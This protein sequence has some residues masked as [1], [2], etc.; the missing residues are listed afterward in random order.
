MHGLP[1][2]VDEL[3]NH[4]E[5]TI[6]RAAACSGRRIWQIA[7]FLWCR[8]ILKSFRPPQTLTR[9]QV[10][11]Y[12]GITT[13]IWVATI[14]FRPEVLP[15][16]L[17]GVHSDRASRYQFADAQ[18]LYESR[19]IAFE[20]V[21]M[22]TGFAPPVV[23]GLEDYL[24]EETKKLVADIDDGHVFD[25]PPHLPQ[26]PTQLAA[27]YSGTV[28]KVIR[29]RLKYGVP[30]ED[31]YNEMWVKILH[32][33][34]VLKFV[35]SAPKRLPA[36]LA[37]EDVLDFFGIDLPEWQA[38][39]KS[40]EKAPNPVKGQATSLDAV[41]R[42]DDIK[43]L[44]D[45]GYFK[46][47]GIVRMLPAACVTEGNFERYL[48]RVVENELKNLFRTLERRFNKE[49]V[50]GEGSCI[51]DNRRVRRLGRDDFDLAWEDTLAG[52]G[53][54]ADSLVDIVRRARLKFPEEFAE[55][56]DDTSLVL[57]DE[58]STDGLVNIKR[59]VAELI[60]VG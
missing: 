36:L 44:D 60:Q 53:I 22:T 21:S 30:V 41:Y 52:E 17:E 19:D 2:D 32:S 38:M 4:Y 42:S 43:A 20:R 31:A 9:D 49:D 25:V 28:A 5:A 59:Q 29:F 23:P 56:D 27:G 7:H 26:N 48:Q 51:Q 45:A 35:R 12:L 15:I 3:L 18:R 37:T 14:R 33:K 46:D 40:Y 54:A 1:R 55:S 58:G 16:P 50:L 47:R 6:K 39:M 10:I 8:G 11:A 57:S 13:P 34:V 24:T